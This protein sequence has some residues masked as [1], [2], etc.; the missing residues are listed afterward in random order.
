L[1]LEAF[2]GEVG[3]TRW[4]MFMLVST[5]KQI[6]DSRSCLD[7]GQRHRQFFS[8][9]MASKASGCPNCECSMT[10]DQVIRMLRKEAAKRNEPFDEDL[11]PR[12][13]CPICSLDCE[14]GQENKHLVAKHFTVAG[15]YSLP[16]SYLYPSLAFALPCTLLFPLF[17]LC[18][19]SA[20]LLCSCQPL[21][22]SLPALVL[23][24]FIGSLILSPHPCR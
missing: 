18:G 14:A 19:L 7:Q 6:S 11:A 20:T 21:S 1:R 8:P 15:M 10:Q 4:F 9:S 12:L 2:T 13:V 3:T 23:S 24:S 16:V 17:G 22:S 5:C